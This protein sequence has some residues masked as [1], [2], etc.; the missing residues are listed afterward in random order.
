MT[1]RYNSRGKAIGLDWS[2]CNDGNPQPEVWGLNPTPKAK[3][4]K[5]IKPVGEKNPNGQRIP[6]EKEREIIR[7]YT[8]QQ[9][10]G[11]QVAAR[12]GVSV[13][14]VFKSLHRNGVEVR[15]KG[16]P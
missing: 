15:P 12:V 4:V 11:L 6:A 14:T 3:P 9:L 10:S 8:E 7:L 16:R 2:V 5:A 13:V 1:L